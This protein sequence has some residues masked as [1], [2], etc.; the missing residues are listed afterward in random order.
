MEFYDIPEFPGYSIN[1]R[2]E[3][4]SPTGVTLIANDH[5]QVRLVKDGRR[6]TRYIGDL[7]ASTIEKELSRSCGQD[8]LL[9]A[10]LAQ[11]RE[12]ASTAQAARSALAERLRLARK[13]NGH[14]LAM[15]GREN[16]DADLSD[17]RVTA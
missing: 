6:S 3:V 15:I 12:A 16:P 1:W 7:L 4:R 5:W 17:L 8:S 14:L 10:E 9:H 13:L 11:A 2:G